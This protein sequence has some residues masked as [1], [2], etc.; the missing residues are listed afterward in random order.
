MLQFGS[1]DLLLTGVISFLEA[2]TC[3][4]FT[5]DYAASACPS[6]LYA[7]LPRTVIDPSSFSKEQLKSTPVNEAVTELHATFLHS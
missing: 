6:A 3:S 2:H 5:P 4:R 1:N 7:A